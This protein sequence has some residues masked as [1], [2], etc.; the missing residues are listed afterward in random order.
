MMPLDSTPPDDLNSKKRALWAKLKY[1][2]FDSKQMDFYAG[3]IEDAKTMPRLEAL[4]GVIDFNSV[5]LLEPTKL[6][7]REVARRLRKGYR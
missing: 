3:Q 4:E 1:T 6:S 5:G 7:Q 2:T